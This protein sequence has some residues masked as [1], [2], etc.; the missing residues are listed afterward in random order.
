MVSKRFILSKIVK[1]KYNIY[2]I[3]T[4]LYGLSWIEIDNKINGSKITEK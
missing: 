1:G 2:I 4:K 3:K